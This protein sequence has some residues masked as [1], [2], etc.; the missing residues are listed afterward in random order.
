MKGGKDKIG[1]RRESVRRSISN[2][3]QRGTSGGYLFEASF[4]LREGEKC[5]WGVFLHM[6][7]GIDCLEKKWG[8]QSIK[9]GRAVI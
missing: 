3:N 2:K 4:P 1:E 9:S 8:T 7:R 6:A 5:Y